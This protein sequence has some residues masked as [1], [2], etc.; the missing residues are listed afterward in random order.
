MHSEMATTYTYSLLWH[1]SPLR[2]RICQSTAATEV[3]DHPAS[4]EVMC[5][6]HIKFPTIIYFLDQDYRY[7][8]IAMQVPHDS[9]LAPIPYSGQKFLAHGGLNQCHIPE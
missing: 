1:Y 3:K 4:L 7:Q 5:G 8:K 9:A 6:Q 2:P